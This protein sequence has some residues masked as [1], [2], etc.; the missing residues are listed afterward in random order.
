MKRKRVLAVASAGGHWVQLLRLRDAYAH[1]EVSYI[2]TNP[3]L[4]PNVEGSRFI[5]VRDASMWDK[6]G[7]LVLSAQIFWAVLS[8]RPDVVISTGAAPG[9]FAILFGR[10]VG[11]RTIWI[12]SIANSEEP[13][14]A[15][16][17]AMR[18]AHVWL[19]QWPHLAASGA[20]RCLG[21]VI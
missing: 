18:V 12:D 7:L 13:S 16:K 4:A 9:F 19:T 3:L 11:A 10:M 5:C 14:K 1:H 17:L 6:F 2:S 20:G 8:F 21:A 15:G